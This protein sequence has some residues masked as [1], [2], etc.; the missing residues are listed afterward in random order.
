MGSSPVIAVAIRVYATCVKNVKGS[1]SSVRIHASERK[2]HIVS[3]TR[4]SAGE[5]E[6]TTT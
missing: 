6:N 3:C 4:I 1:F 5:T 2:K